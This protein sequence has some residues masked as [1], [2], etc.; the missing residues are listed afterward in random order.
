ME[1]HCGGPS[2]TSVLGSHMALQKA[3]DSGLC[4]LMVSVRASANCLVEA[5]SYVAAIL[6]CF[7]YGHS[8]QHNSV[9]CMLHSNKH[10]TVHEMLS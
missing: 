5:L 7:L 1:Y 2:L 9:S 6:L 3:R 4:V 10:L 8:C